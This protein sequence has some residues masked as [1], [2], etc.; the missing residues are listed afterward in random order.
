MKFIPKGKTLYFTA[1]F[2]LILIPSAT[3]INIAHGF[4]GYSPDLDFYAFFIAHVIC[5]LVLN[6]Y[7]LGLIFGLFSHKN[8]VI[9]SISS[10]TYK[11]ELPDYQEKYE[12]T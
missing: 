9:S 8:T 11:Y 7:L 10:S 4:K 6:M 2:I 3:W 5:L 12:I 1:Y